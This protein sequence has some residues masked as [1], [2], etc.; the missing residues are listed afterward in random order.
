M[1]AL[2]RSSVLSINILLEKFRTEDYGII[3]CTHI[4]ELLIDGIYFFYNEQ[5]TWA[6]P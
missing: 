1:K 4:A 3:F 6:E 2:E 5:V